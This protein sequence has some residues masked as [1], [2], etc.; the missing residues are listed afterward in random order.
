MGVRL[1][2][3]FSSP[4]LKSNLIQ[5]WNS[6]HMSLTQWFRSYFFNPLLRAMRNA[7]HRLPEAGVVLVCQTA[8]MVLIGL[9]HGI[10]W[11]FVLWG[12]WHALGLF[13]NNRWNV[14][15]RTRIEA[16]TTTTFRKT[17]V[18]ILGIV[19]TFNFVS[20]GWVLFA[21]NTPADA[22]IIFKHLF[23]IS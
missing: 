15:T 3:N 18:R 20:L 22:L 5:F 1:P 23:F 16:W 14:L 7:K 4:Y 19:I 11:N 2:E 8:T 12:L 10:T 21:S 13:L 6:W 17:A 9:W